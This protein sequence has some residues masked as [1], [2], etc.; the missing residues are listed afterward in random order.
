MRSTLIYLKN[1]FN[2]PDIIIAE[3]GYSN[4]GGLDDPDRIAFIQ[5]C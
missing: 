2:N 5:V 1:N 4:V 3:N